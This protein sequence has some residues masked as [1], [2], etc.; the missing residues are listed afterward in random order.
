MCVVL[1]DESTSPQGNNLN[2]VSDV[3]TTREDLSIISTLSRR[4]LHMIM[5]HFECNAF[6]Y[7]CT[8]IKVV[9]KGMAVP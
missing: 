6:A 2:S 5:Y 7:N 9:L 8:Q 4:L 1:T 3:S